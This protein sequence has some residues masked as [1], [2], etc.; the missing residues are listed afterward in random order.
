MRSDT[1]ILEDLLQIKWH[2]DWIHYLFWINQTNVK[3]LY[4][5]CCVLSE[6]IPNPMQYLLYTDSIHDIGSQPYTEES[7]TVCLHMNNF[8]FCTD[9]FLAFDLFFFECYRLLR[10][11]LKFMKLFYRE[12][13]LPNLTYTLYLRS[14]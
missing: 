12:Y 10:N 7:P 6:C 2:N 14:R 9:F 8:I 1:R 5:F 11:R 13:I 3:L 4:V